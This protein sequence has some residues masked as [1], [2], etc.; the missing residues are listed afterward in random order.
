MK[1]NI[2]GKALL[3]ICAAGVSTSLL[4]GSMFFLGLKEAENLLDRQVV[5]LAGNITQEAENFA[6]DEVRKRMESVIL[7]KAYYVEIFMQELED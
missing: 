3:F 4:L 2:H 7:Q 1:M 6:E 5:T